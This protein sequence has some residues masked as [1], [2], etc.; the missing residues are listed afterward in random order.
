MKAEVLCYPGRARKDNPR[1]L[2]TNLPHRPATVY[3][4]LYCGRGD[5]ENRLKELQ[6]GLAMDRTSCS[7]FAANQ[8]RLLFSIAAYVLFQALQTVRAR[9]RDR[10]G[11]G[12]DA[13]R[14]AGEDRGLGRALGA[15]HRAALAAGLPVARHACDVAALAPDPAIET[16][17]SRTP[18]YLCQGR[19]LAD[20][21][22]AGARA[23]V[24]HVDAARLD[25]CTHLVIGGA[26]TAL[27]YSR[28][29]GER[30]RLP[31]APNVGVWG[32]FRGPP[33]S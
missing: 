4:R 3:T 12:L 22:P 1:F 8:L 5:M 2:V 9:H 30:A 27:Q 23:R 19:T 14:A 29:P 24:P 18:S 28:T 13:A 16:T 20:Q 15:A 6:H 25:P 7:R 17:V 21:P 32:P 33:R 10:T 11:A 31:G 26:V